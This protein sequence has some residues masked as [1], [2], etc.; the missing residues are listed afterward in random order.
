[1]KWYSQALS[2]F[3]ILEEQSHWSGVKTLKWFSDL[4]AEDLVGHTV[5]FCS[6]KNRSCL[7]K[8][9]G[10]GNSRETRSLVILIKLSGMQMSLNRS[11]HAV[12]MSAVM[13]NYWFLLLTLL[14]RQ[15]S[16]SVINAKYLTT[17][18]LIWIPPR[19]ECYM[20]QWSL[21]I[22]VTTSQETTRLT[23]KMFLSD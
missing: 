3:S 14:T 17:R 15:R 12:M 7:H 18:M 11:F 23:T 4:T 19:L 9:A 10:T 1:M 13:K 8:Y 22:T 6:E 16:Y 20:R 5:L 2:V 21:P